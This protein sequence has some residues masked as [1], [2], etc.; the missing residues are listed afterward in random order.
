MFRPFTL[1]TEINSCLNMSVPPSALAPSKIKAGSKELPVTKWATPQPGSTA[2]HSETSPISLAQPEPTATAAVAQDYVKPSKKALAKRT[3]A[4]EVPPPSD[5]DE[6]S[7]PSATEPPTDDEA[8]AAEEEKKAA[9]KRKTKKAAEET[10]VMTDING[11]AVSTAQEDEVPDWKKQ[12][13]YLEPANRTLSDGTPVY[14]G[15]C[16]NPKTINAVF[17]QFFA[18]AV[19]ATEMIAGGYANADLPN[20]KEKV[21]ASRDYVGFKIEVEGVDSFGK[22]RWMPV[23][24]AQVSVNDEFPA[25]QGKVAEKGFGTY[26]VG[27]KHK[28]TST[29]A[30]KM[31]GAPYML[32]MSKKKM[33]KRTRD[34]DA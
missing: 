10:F 8:L 4:I 34:E 31:A 26:K 17:G 9:K 14:N 30:A 22:P 24:T 7:P 15:D 6:E 1:S 20:C 2:P 25:G 18:K 13:D 19:G 28:C 32:N 33:V 12:I 21:R 27:P 5:D 11:N 23:A 3:K 29:D 16:R